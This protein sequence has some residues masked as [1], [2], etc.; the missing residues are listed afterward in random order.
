MNE[1]KGLVEKRRHGFSCSAFMAGA[2]QMKRRPLSPASIRIRPQSCPPPQLPLGFD[3][4][5][6]AHTPCLWC[7]SWGLGFRV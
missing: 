7:Q 3:A 1:M 4:A 6:A 2:F 5:P